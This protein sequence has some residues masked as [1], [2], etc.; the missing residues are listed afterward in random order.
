MSQFWTHSKYNRH[1]INLRF[2]RFKESTR[3]M[4]CIWKIHTYLTF[5]L[6]D[7]VLLRNKVN[8]RD[9]PLQISQLV[10]TS[11]LV[12]YQLKW[13]NIQMNYIINNADNT[14]GSRRRRLFV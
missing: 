9:N 14:F 13:Y 8:I 5:P 1:D 11:A 3:K 12:M 4:S 6:P 10:Q 2:I 7:Y